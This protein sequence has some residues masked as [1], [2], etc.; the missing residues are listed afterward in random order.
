MP[1]A[2]K[3]I[4]KNKWTK[5]QAIGFWVLLAGL[6]LFWGGVAVGSYATQNSINERE[7]LK[8]QAVEEYKA[9]ASKE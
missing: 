3:K 4:N 6:S 2:T 7:S 8:A 9:S 5:A 1:E